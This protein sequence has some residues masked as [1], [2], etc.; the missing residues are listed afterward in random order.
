MKRFTIL[1]LL[2][3]AAVLVP[4]PAYVFSDGDETTPA[5]QTRY[6]NFVDEDGDGICDNRQTGG[7]GLGLGKGN[8]DTFVD[9]DGDGV[10]DTYQSGLRKGKG[11]GRG[12]GQGAGFLSADGDGVCDTS[13]GDTRNVKSRN[14]KCRGRGGK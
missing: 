7:Q 12:Y 10:C 11:Q 5:P 8:R 4:V 13:T 3:L 2:L 6:A 14:G 9:E 1:S